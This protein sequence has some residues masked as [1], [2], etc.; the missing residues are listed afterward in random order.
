MGEPGTGFGQGSVRMVSGRDGTILWTASGSA[1]G[2]QF[3]FSVS[4]CRSI[5]ADGVADVLVGSPGFAGGI[6]RVEILSGVTGAPLV[7]SPNYGGGFGTAIDHVGTFDNDVSAE[8][9]ISAP[10]LGR[11]YILDA[12]TLTN[13]WFIGGPASEGFGDVVAAIGDFTGDLRN[14]IAFGSPLAG[15]EPGG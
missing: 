1:A 10:G 2:D 14:E 6:G 13:G 12:V 4:Y 5:D 9:A 11:I 15:L 8:V 3:G 7:V